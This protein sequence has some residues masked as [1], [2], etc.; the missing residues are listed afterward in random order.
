MVTLAAVLAAVP[1]E[2]TDPVVASASPNLVFDLTT[3]WKG[4][5][6]FDATSYMFDNYI[7]E[8][9]TLAWMNPGYDNAAKV[10]FLISQYA[11]VIT[12]PLPNLLSQLTHPL[13]RTL[14]Q[15]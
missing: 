14:I 9:S 4:F 13:P 10:C 12:F 3:E 6:P 5:S 2:A 8:T 1:L 11:P 7:N 15:D